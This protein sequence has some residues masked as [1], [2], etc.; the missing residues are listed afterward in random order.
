MKELFTLEQVEG[1]DHASVNFFFF[2][3]LNRSNI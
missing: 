1:L 3:N 2:F